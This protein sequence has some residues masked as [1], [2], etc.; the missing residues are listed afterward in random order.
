[1][2]SEQNLKSTHNVDESLG[3]VANMVVA[4]DDRVA[5]VDD[6]AAGVDSRNACVVDEVASVDGT[7]NKG[8]DKVT[9][10]IHGV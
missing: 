1:M 3:G 5:D 8:D 7:V 2:A 10:V 6:R 4:V 9:E